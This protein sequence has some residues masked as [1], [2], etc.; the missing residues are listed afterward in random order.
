MERHEQPY[1]IC[2]SI[3]PRRGGEYGR[4]SGSMDRTD[5]LNDRMLMLP[6]Y[7]GMSSDDVLF[8]V[9]NIRDFYRA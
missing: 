2:H 3:H 1:T 5:Y 6:L 4:V 8:V 7:Y 9:E